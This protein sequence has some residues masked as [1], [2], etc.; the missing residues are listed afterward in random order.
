MKETAAWLY[1]L[2]S[3]SRQVIWIQNE[4]FVNG[5]K[6]SGQLYTIKTVRMNESAALNYVTLVLSQGQS[7][8]VAFLS[9]KLTTLPL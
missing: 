4:D 5:V 8:D 6:K 3:G 2:L 7:S 1:H 9:P